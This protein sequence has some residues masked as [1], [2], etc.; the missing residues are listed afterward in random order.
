MRAAFLTLLLLLASCRGNGGGDGSPQGSTAGGSASSRVEPAIAEAVALYDAAFTA[1]ESTRADAFRRAAEALRRSRGDSALPSRARATAMLFEADARRRAGA[2][3]EALALLEE[4]IRSHA[5][6]KDL[7]RQARSDRLRLLLASGADKETL[8]RAARWFLQDAPPDS[9]TARVLLRIAAEAKDA[10]L[11]FRIARR[12]ASQFRDEEGLLQK[13]SFVMT[14]AI[15]GLRKDNMISDWY[16]L[17]PFSVRYDWYGGGGE[18]AR[19]GVVEKCGDPDPQKQYEGKKW[20]PLKKKALKA[21]GGVSLDAQFDGGTDCFAYAL[22]YIRSP[23]DRRVRFMVGSDDAMKVWVNGELLFKWPYLRGA[24]PDQDAFEVELKKGWNRVLVKIFNHHGP[25]GFYLRVADEEGL[26]V[27]G[28][29]YDR[30]RG[31]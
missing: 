26:P 6:E 2:S 12:L 30:D 14:K 5:S 22:T 28:L 18:F 21:D 8:E 4:L 16:L 17:G 24:A 25:W 15:A 29:E 11:G 27:S 23:E 9:E 1:P 19:G 10:A 13:A 3:G 20:R 7:V 31:G